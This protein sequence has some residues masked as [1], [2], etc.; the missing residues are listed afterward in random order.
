MCFP[1]KHQQKVTSSYVFT[2]DMKLFLS[3]LPE[4]MEDRGQTLNLLFHYFTETWSFLSLARNLL[5]LESQRKWGH[6]D[7]S[8]GGI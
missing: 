5:G 2:L 4:F 3:A 8:R 6:L 1:F 7:D